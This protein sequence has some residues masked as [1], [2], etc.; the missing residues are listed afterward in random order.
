MSSVHISATCPSCGA[1]F[2]SRLIQIIGDAT[3]IVLTGNKET[4][5]FCGE[6]AEVQEGT[7]DR[8]DGVLSMIYGPRVT[9]QK[10]ADL[11]VAAVQAYRQKTPADDL[12]KEIN[13]IDPSFSSFFHKFG[14]C[15]VI[16]CLIVVAIRS[17]NL[18]IKL[19][20]NQLLAQIQ[21]KK[22]ATIILL[23]PGGH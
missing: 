1:F 6:L 2:K 23:N 19:D 12:A 10:L 22:P 15:S 8:A 18:D 4:C 11:E 16:L 14:A 20:A 13:K 9:K 5:P 21:D 7:F 17:C 3:G